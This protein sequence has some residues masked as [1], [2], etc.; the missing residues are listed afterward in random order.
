[1]CFF[2]RKRVNVNANVRTSLLFDFCRI[3]E[4]MEVALQNVK[5]EVS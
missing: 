2:K 5:E 4:E 3:Q 1:M